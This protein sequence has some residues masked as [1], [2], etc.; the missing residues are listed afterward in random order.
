MRGDRAGRVRWRARF[1][2]WCEKEDGHVGYD[3]HVQRGGVVATLDLAR[4]LIH[5]PEMP[6]YTAR[7]ILH[8]KGFDDAIQLP[9]G[10]RSSEIKAAVD[11]IYDFLSAMNEFMVQHGWERLEETLPQQRSA[12]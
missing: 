3:R 9:Y 12:A 7:P 11:D 2:V 5:D 10:L 8:P 1:D 4:D 6:K